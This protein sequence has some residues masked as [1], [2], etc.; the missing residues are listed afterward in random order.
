[1]R[2]LAL[3]LLLVACSSEGGGGDGSGGT[4][5][6]AEPLVTGLSITGVSLYQGVEVPLKA[7]QSAADRPAPLVMGRRALARVFVQPDAD[8][9]PREVRARVELGEGTAA[10]RVFEVTQAV[11][12]PSWQPSLSSTLNVELPGDAIG[13]ETTLGVS[14]LEVASG[15]PGA[16]AGG[17]KYPEQGAIPLGA[18]SSGAALRMVIVPV[19]YDADGSGR[20]P[21]LGDA[22]LAKYRDTL[23]GLYP[24]PSVELRVRDPMPWTTTILPT[25]E[26]WNELLQSVLSLRSKDRLANQAG[27]DEYYFALVSP[28]ASFDDYCG[29][30]G[31][32]LGQSF[33]ADANDE[34]LRGSVGLGFA[35][36]ASAD[37]VAH[38]TGHTHGRLHAPCMTYGVDEDPDFPDPG[39]G[40][41]T[42][43]YDLSTGKLFDPGGDIHDFMG[44][45]EPVWIGA[46][47]YGALFERMSLVSSEAGGAAG[48][49]A[50]AFR[51]VSIAGSGAMTTGPVL[52]LGRTPHRS[53]VTVA[54]LDFQGRHRRWINAHLYRYSH[55]SGRLLLLPEPDPT[56]SEIRLG[57]Q[58]LKLR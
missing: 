17:A 19:R 52:W 43:G 24:T 48:T 58:T 4:G 27:P 18:G 3:T 6:S 50:Q 34:F 12:G 23:L 39:G 14:L 36:Q 10:P 5:G 47:N 32:D 25:G 46:Y 55:G 37:T 2:R 28:A 20:L 56:V 54:L 13:P 21:E 26:G 45:C 53:P 51:A 31:C 40:L 7:G 41:G 29:S 11:T 1:M 22:Q 15:A 16:S 35:G 8:W 44:Y 42:W 30:G 33:V 9:Q 49:S 57:D 38:E